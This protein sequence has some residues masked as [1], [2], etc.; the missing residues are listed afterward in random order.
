MKYRYAKKLSFKTIIILL[1]AIFSALIVIY[2]FQQPIKDVKYKNVILRFDLNLRETKNIPVYP[3]E[4][5]VNEL[6]S[7][8]KVKKITFIV[9]NT[10]DAFLTKLEAVEI[11]LKLSTALQIFDSAFFSNV[12]EVSSFENLK[13]T[14]ENPF[15]VLIPPSIANETYVS[16]SNNVVY[17]S[18]KNRHE[19]DLATAKFILSSLGI[20]V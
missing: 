12:I 6:I 18:G 7:N 14:Q 17:I 20:K 11:T 10:S 1:I 3:N 13:S 15:I 9:K 5:A 2:Y 16:V 19:F 8:P 4:S